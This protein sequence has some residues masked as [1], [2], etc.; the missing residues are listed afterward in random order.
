MVVD[1]NAINRQLISTLLKYQGHAICEAADGREALRVAE[2]MHPDLI[3][4]D[5]LMPT[6]DGF[7]FVRRLRLNPRVQDTEVIFYTAHYH[8]R[9]AQALAAQCQVAHVLVKP[10]EPADIFRA[11]D[12]V[13]N[14][15]QPAAS[16]RRKGGTSIGSIWNS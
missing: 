1:D 10:C 5:I 6:M 9:E 12:Q 16:A 3:I 11:V 4:S 14:R 2:R 8:E 13:L 7:E 15:Q